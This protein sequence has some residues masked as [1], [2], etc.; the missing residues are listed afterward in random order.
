[1][2]APCIIMYGLYCAYNDIPMSVVIAYLRQHGYVFFLG[3][4]VLS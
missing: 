4:S 2:N 3:S 1:M